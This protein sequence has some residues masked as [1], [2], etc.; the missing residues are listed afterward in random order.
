[1][2][3]V[4]VTKRLLWFRMSKSNKCWG[5]ANELFE[6][7]QGQWEGSMAERHGPHGLEEKIF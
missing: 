7:F 1:M 3:T 2:G 6:G 4:L 5:V